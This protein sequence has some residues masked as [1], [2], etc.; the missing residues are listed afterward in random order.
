MIYWILYLL[1][2]VTAELVYFKLADR[3]AIID[4]PNQRS[5]HNK[6]TIRGG[7]VIFI[8]GLWLLFLNLSFPW[9]YFIGGV[10]MVALISFA[11]DLKPRSSWARFLVHL[12]AIL[13]VF[14]Q[15]Q[16][17][18]WHWLLVLLAGIV[19]IG[20]L[21]AF[22]FMDGINGI[23]GIYAFVNFSTFLFIDANVIDFTDSTLL[24][25]LMVANS[26]F[27]F[28]NFRKHARCFAGD[29]GSV[30]LSFVQIFFLLQLMRTTDSLFWALM[31]FVF[32]IDSVITIIYRI[33]RR[34]NIFKAHRTHLYQFLA[35]ELKW[36]HRLVAVTYGTFQSVINVILIYYLT[37]GSYL[38]PLIATSAI[39][40]LYITMREI[41]IRKINWTQ[42]PES[43]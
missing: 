40:I 3:Y 43:I 35:N 1:I 16:L 12:I 4:K 27:L 25:G 20:T 15:V 37:A 7:G 17:Y 5:S 2:V 11:D 8:V 6:P 38:I 28:F 13:L 33:K 24:I 29:V 30:T 41:V 26:A 9:P 31:F 18:D 22:N 10:S 23:T 36:D 21:N 34:E 39:L 42:Q 14:Y 19:C 32:G